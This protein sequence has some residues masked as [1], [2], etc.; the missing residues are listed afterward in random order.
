MKHAIAKIKL[1]SINRN[2]HNIFTEEDDLDQVKCIAESI[3]NIGLESPIVVYKCGGNANNPEYKI[4]SGHKRFAALKLAGYKSTDEIPCIINDAPKDAQDEREILLQNNLSRKKPEE[5]EKQ[6]IEANNIWNIMEPARRQ[7]LSNEYKRK[8]LAANKGCS[9]K[10][11][12]DNF[13]ARLDYIK[14]QTGLEVSNRTV[15]SIINKSLNKFNEG[16]PLPAKKEKKVEFK[17]VYSRIKSL[18][19]VIE[20]YCNGDKVNAKEKRMLNNVRASLVE[21]IAEI[22]EA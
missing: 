17:D 19:G 16:F 22:E 5:L 11:I 13:R 3:K 7:Q 4:L 20:V 15:T 18:K 1:S 8:F 12:R 14:E 21:V 10:Y 9:E 6:V 2:E